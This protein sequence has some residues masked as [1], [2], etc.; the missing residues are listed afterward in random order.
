VQ[1]LAAR[2]SNLISKA[3]FDLIEEMDASAVIERVW[4]LLHGIGHLCSTEFA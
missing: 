2:R 4:A 3:A 1:Y